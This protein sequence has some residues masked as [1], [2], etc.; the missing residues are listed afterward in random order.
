VGA[1]VE[2]LVGGE[3]FT[4]HGLVL[5]ARSPVFKAGLSVP[6]MTK[7]DVATNT[8]VI[9]IE[10]MEAP[11]FRSM[12]AFIYTDTWAN[13]DGQDKAAM[14]QRLLAATNRYDIRRLKLMC[15]D[16]LCSHIDIG[17]M[18]AILALAE[19]HPCA[20]LK[21]ACLEYLGFVALFAAMGTKEYESLTLSYPTITKE[22]ICNVIARNKEKG[23]TVGWNNQE[24]NQDAVIKCFLI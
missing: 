2:F 20:V 9:E 15:E 16:M 24:N 3:T 17:S 13:M 6:T 12:L 22:L 5:R 1:D 21:K 11:V 4:A 19:K 7:E 23:K 18:A 10:D 14:A 8:A